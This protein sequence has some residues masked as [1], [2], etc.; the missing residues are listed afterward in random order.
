MIYISFPITVLAPSPLLLILPVP[1][2]SEPIHILTR[3]HHAEGHT[4]TFPFILQLA[5]TIPP[6]I[7]NPLSQSAVPEPHIKPLNDPRISLF[8]PA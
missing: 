3:Y 1:A 5:P 4:S 7:S 8:L 6:P 2:P